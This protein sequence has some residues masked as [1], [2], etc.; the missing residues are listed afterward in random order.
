MLQVLLGVV[1]WLWVPYEGGGTGE[2]KVSLDATTVKHAKWQ[3][4]VFGVTGVGTLSVAAW[5]I[6]Y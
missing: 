3:L 5:E 1:T 2:I 4:E 6:Q